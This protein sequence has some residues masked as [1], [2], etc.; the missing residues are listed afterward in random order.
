MGAERHPGAHGVFVVREGGLNPDP[1]ARIKNL[2]RRQRDG[3]IAMTYPQGW[4]WLRLR[5]AEEHPGEIVGGAA[6]LLAVSS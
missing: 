3:P 2:L 5:S 6:T 1:I 4:I